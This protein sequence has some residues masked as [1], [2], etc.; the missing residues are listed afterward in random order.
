L[1]ATPAPSRPAA[2]ARSLKFL[3]AGLA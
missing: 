3:P 1:S 2:S